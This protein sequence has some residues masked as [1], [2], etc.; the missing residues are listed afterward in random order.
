MNVTFETKY[1]RN[2]GKNEWLTPPDLIKKL[3][4]FD[5]DPCSPIKRPWPTAKKHLTIKDDG[6]KTPWN[7]RVFC[8]PPYGDN[9][10]VWLKKCAAHK[11]AIA[12]TFARTETKMF[13]ESV[14]KD[15][16]AV[17]F[18][19]GRLK[20]YHLDGTPGDSAG[21]PS[22]LIAYDM[23][24]A[25]ALQN[26]GIAGQMLYITSPHFTDIKGVKQQKRITQLIRKY[27]A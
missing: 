24:N 26:S 4:S 15:A 11:N 22:V 19:K 12:L 2:S 17:L 20:F 5:L 10:A 14:W 27:I 23:A 21:A 7:G 16:V 18:I 8:N 6:L 13:F 25:K 1:G 9:T 3:G